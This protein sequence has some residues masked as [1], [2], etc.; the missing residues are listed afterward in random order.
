MF[1]FL[2]DSPVNAPGLSQRERRIAVER[3]REN[4]TGIENKHL[5]PRQVL[6]AFMDYKL[7]F[8]FVLGC[9]CTLP[10]YIGTPFTPY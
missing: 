6:E 9:V 10:L 3:L 2:P 4:Q 5:K 1:I 8:F 7:Y